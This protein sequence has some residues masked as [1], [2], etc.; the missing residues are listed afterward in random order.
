M[1]NDE[2]ENQ[3]E[4]QEE[5]GE[6]QEG[7]QDQ[8]EEEQQEEDE[9]QEEETSDGNGDDESDKFVSGVK[10]SPELVE[11]SMRDQYYSGISEFDQENLE[12][13]GSSARDRRRGSRT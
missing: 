8:Q 12:A 5:D 9:Q 3:Q 7:E 4:H 1:A 2:D 11:A 13:A 6:E 10:E